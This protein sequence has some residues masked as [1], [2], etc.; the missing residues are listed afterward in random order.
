MLLPAAVLMQMC[1]GATYS[2]AVFVQPLRD[3]TGLLQGTVQLPFSV[4]YFAFPVTVI[5]S[6]NLL[7]RI[8]PRKC[9]CGGGVL[10]GCG[11]ILAAAGGYHF[12]YT[13][14]GIGLL[15]GIGAG[16]AYIVP[17]A[18]C[19]QWFPRQKGLVT[20]IAV[21]GFGGGA[22]LVSQIAGH[23]LTLSNTTPYLIF[24]Y[25]GLFFLGGIF[26]P[27][28]LMQHPPHFVKTARQRLALKQI[29]GRRLFRVLF[30]AM[31]IGLAAGF[32]VNAN[33]KELYTAADVRVSILA[34]S[35]FAMANAAGRIV[36]GLVFDRIKPL[37]AITGN[38][39]A[40]ALA[41]FGAPWILQSEP[42]LLA[43]AVLTGFN[44]GGVLVLYASTAAQAWGSQNVGQVYAWLFAANIP[45][46]LSPLLAGFGYDAT[47][48]FTVPLIVVAVGLATMALFVH[49]NSHTLG[50]AMSD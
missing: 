31:C 36:W 40:Q 44:Y 45:A 17:I 2:W 39:A 46:A 11:W 38:L 33:L 37:T 7:H 16:M 32:A 34:V 49:S 27:G 14:L 22:A 21:A 8:G 47:G 18:I 12:T 29:F 30:P 13:V 28:L 1:L 35:F 23:L 42:G 9:A 20:G 48:S 5:V 41:L 24:M 4:F 6:G 10:F 3:Y 50:S 19:I 15:A 43:F 25:F 26:L